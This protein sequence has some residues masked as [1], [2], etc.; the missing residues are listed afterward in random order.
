MGS[1]TSKEDIY[2]CLKP[3]NQPSIWTRN[4]T[5]QANQSASVPKL[6]PALQSLEYSNSKEALEKASATSKHN[7]NVTIDSGWGKD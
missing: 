6:A 4:K 3:T 2:Q 5:M 1:N 7:V